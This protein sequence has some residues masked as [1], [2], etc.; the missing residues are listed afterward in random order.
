MSAETYYQILNV[1]PEAG[2]FELK[3][4]YRQ[5]ALQWHPQRVPIEQRE[6]AA[7]SFKRIVEAYY[8][9]I[10]KESRKIY[11]KQNV[12]TQSDF[13]SEA[14]SFIEPVVSTYHPDSF[15]AYYRDQLLNCDAFHM[16]WREVLGGPGPK[17]VAAL[18]FAIILFFGRETVP[19]LSLNLGFVHLSMPVLAAMLYIFLEKFRDFLWDYVGEE[20]L[21]DVAILLVCWMILVG[22]TLGSFSKAWTPLVTPVTAP[23]AEVIEKPRDIYQTLPVNLER[24]NKPIDPYAVNAMKGKGEI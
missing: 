23:E 18:M 2:R 22:F 9:L 19:F 12:V 8:V 21:Y 4:A 7:K 6:E 16:N 5:L 11:D 13:K 24:F 10:N 20:E 17:I 1:T 3:R 14:W 15:N